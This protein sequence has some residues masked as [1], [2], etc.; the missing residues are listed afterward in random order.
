MLG[1]I[2]G[3]RFAASRRSALSRE[4]AFFGG[5]LIVVPRKVSR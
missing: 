5:A 1:H 2:R 4:T 3:E